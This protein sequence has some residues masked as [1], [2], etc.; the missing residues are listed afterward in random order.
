MEAQ[1]A[2]MAAQ[3]IRAEIRT[4]VLTSLN[5]V[6]RQTQALQQTQNLNIHIV[7]ANTG[8]QGLAANTPIFQQ[9]P[10]RREQLPEA[11]PGQQEE[12]P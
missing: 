12:E 10:Q 5:T 4:N 1:E 3:E 7:P 6:V 2:K 9:A 8:G 11:Q